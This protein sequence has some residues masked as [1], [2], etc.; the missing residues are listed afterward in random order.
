MSRDD[1]A[2]AIIDEGRRRG[3][4]ERGIVIALATALVE[5]NLQNYANAKVPASLDLPHDA[6]GSDGFS[7]GLF[8]QQVRRGANGD[9]WWSDAASCMDPTR[10]A[11]MFYDRLS[12]LDYNSSAHSAGWYAQQVQ[13]SAFPD[14]YDQRMGEAQALYDRLSGQT[15]GDVS[16]YD[17]D[18]S[19]RF[20]FGGPRDVSRLRGVCVHT[21]ESAPG[22][23]AQDVTNY[24]ISSQT[25]SYNV[26]VG[27]D[28][29]RILQNTD[30]WT[31]WA[32][33]NKG[34]DILLH[35]CFVAQSAW[36]RDQW[37]AQD[38]MLTAGATVIAHWCNTYNWP[39]RKVTADSLPGVLGHGDTRVWGGTDHS[40]P[41]PNFPYDVVLAKAEALL[42]PS[43][44]GGF[45]AALTDAEQRELL[46]GVRYIRDQ[47]GPGQPDWPSLG[48]NDKGEPLTLRDAIADSRRRD[49]DIT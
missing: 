45:M 33:G 13:K 49:G 10:S 21:T 41:G 4:G 40:D 24:Q 28:G 17:L 32:T 25:G 6:V 23:T 31:P 42:A 34:N 29:V 47:L 20:T 5:S 46:D 15:G 12:R 43:T 48:H 22:A 2:R 36:T 14:R 19:A 9:W 18:W 11:G 26:M 8:Q 38:K 37:L 16:Y 39:I 27:Q 35:L 30:D 3:I 1:Y 7:V 44:S